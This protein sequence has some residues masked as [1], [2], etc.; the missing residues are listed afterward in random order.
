MN[1]TAQQR[2]GIWTTASSS[3][4]LCIV[5][6]CLL[7]AYWASVIADTGTLAFLGSDSFL[8]VD[9]IAK[10]A[11]LAWYDQ[12]YLSQFGLQGILLS[13][14]YKACNYPGITAFSLITAQVFAAT[15]AA[16]YGC[17]TPLIKR[18]LGLVGVVVFWMTLAFSP[19][20]ATFSHSI[21]WA[22]FSMALPMVFCACAADRLFQGS[23]SR[24]GFIIGL[25][26]LILVRSLCGYEYITTVTLLTFA[27]YLIATLDKERTPSLMHLVMLFGACMAGFFLA[28]AIHWVQLINIPNSGG[29]AYVIG[30][31]STHTGAVASAGDVDILLSILRSQPGNEAVIQAL[32]SDLGAHEFLFFF[33]SL[34]QYL[35]LPALALGSYFS[36]MFWP[37]A[38]AALLAGIYS[39][40]CM[41]KDRTLT[42]ITPFAVWSLAVFMTLLAV[43]SWQV[44]A[45]R[46]MTVHY[47]L[48]GQIFA[49]ALVPFAALWLW[50]IL[51]FYLGSNYTRAENPSWYWALC[52]ALL[53]M[54]LINQQ[55]KSSSAQADTFVD[56]STP[57]GANAIA[58]SLDSL[59]TRKIVSEAARAQ[60]LDATQIIAHGWA[61]SKNSGS[62][63][64]EVLV[65]GR[66]I[67]ASVTYTP[68]PDVLNVMPGAPLMTGFDIV[69]VVPS[70]VTAD[71]VSIVVRDHHGNRKVMKVP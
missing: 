41:I 20:V 65:D 22:F 61:F 58:S 46:H 25:V 63:G 27:G 11:D 30:R 42:R 64:M 10:S 59:T 68:R 38:L 57:G 33:T 1:V 62:V 36:I 19:W 53:L 45:W 3:I 60:N 52:V 29:I 24:W 12:V 18:H 2:M 54:L 7:Y 9:R 31:A 67:P 13:L 14:L 4:P 48:N 17:V 5:F 16:I 35:F 15:T 43:L 23:R 50:S 34:K 69:S 71:R 37:F 51:R 56:I 6:S 40:M 47:H 49:M 44:L 70:V 39:V 66:S 28:L 55:G 8:I 26:L 32:S 21:Y